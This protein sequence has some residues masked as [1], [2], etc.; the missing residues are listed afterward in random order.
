M[1]L[2]KETKYWSL[3]DMSKTLY[4]L[5]ITKYVYALIRALE[6]TKNVFFTFHQNYF[7]KIRSGRF[8]NSKVHALPLNT[9]EL[10]HLFCSHLLCH[11][12]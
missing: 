5:A 10:T 3:L 2:L 7:D 9:I 4:Q 1:L 11:Q 8:L 12:G 6:N